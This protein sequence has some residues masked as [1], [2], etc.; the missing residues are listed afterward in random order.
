MI[1]P[2]MHV[3]PILSIDER[4]LSINVSDLEARVAMRSGAKY[5]S[6]NALENDDGTFALRERGADDRD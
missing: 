4:V 5:V 6:G 2:C 3:S 1:Q